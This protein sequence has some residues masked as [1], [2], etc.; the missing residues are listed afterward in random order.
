[1]PTDVCILFFFLIVV[2]L[3]FILIVPSS[4]LMSSQ[5]FHV[6]GP[7]MVREGQSSSVDLTNNAARPAPWPPGLP[8]SARPQPAPT[9]DTVVFP[10]VML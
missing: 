1:M 9:Y 10:A 8:R 5:N 2:V 3:A 7:C 4:T 6:K